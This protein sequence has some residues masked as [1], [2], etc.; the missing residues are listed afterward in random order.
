MQILSTESAAVSQGGLSSCPPHRSGRLPPEGQEPPGHAP[1]PGSRCA[2]SSH[3]GGCAILHRD[4]GH[5]TNGCHGTGRGCGA[6]CVSLQERTRLELQI[7]TGSKGLPAP[8][9]RRPLCD[10]TKH[11]LPPL[12]PLPSGLRME[13]LSPLHAHLEHHLSAEM[14]SLPLYLPI[15][16]SSCRSFGETFPGHGT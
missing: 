4:E 16:P 8:K 10:I 5:R 11:L 3:P 13:E 2:T 9:N 6:H 7:Q 12:A 1:T 15:C 14:P